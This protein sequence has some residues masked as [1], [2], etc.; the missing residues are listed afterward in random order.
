MIPDWMDKRTAQSMLSMMGPAKYA[1][2][3]ATNAKPTDFQ[4]ELKAA[5]ITETDPRYQSLTQAKL[6]KDTYIPAQEVSA[7]ADLIDPI[8][9]EVSAQ[10]APPPL[11]PVTSSGRTSATSSC[12]STASPAR[13]CL[14]CSR[15]R[16]RTRPQALASRSR[17]NDRIYWQ[18]SHPRASVCQR[19]AI[20]V[21]DGGDH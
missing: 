19:V 14:D 6:N 12:R 17:V 21:T 2:M 18:P 13:P 5:G 16:R 15:W 8:T 7:T 9:H 10:R 20:A 1:E 3:V 11:R 4:R